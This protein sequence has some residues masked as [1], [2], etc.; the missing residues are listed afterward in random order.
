MTLAQEPT[1]TTPKTRKP[2]YGLA[3]AG[4]TVALAGLVLG[5]IP[6]LFIFAW[7]LGATALV[8]S[9]IGRKHGLGK[10]GIVVS[11][12]AIVMGFVGVGIVASATSKLEHDLNSLNSSVA[13]A[14][15]VPAAPETSA[16]PATP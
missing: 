15:V 8:F 1:I 3:I 9:I 16:P 11:A 2:Y 6:I 12:A 4:F 7:V 5:L 10:A 14:P 13:T